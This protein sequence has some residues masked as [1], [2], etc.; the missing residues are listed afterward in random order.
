MRLSPAKVEF[1]SGK[2]LKLVQDT[3]RIHLLDNQDL[4]LRAVSVV[5]Y[6]NLRAEEDIDDE[7]D[8]LLSQHRGEIDAMEMDLGMLRAKMKRQVAKK[9]GF[10]L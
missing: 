10:I 2:I 6:E 1:L 7:V 8:V 9:R 5:I 4:L 3:G